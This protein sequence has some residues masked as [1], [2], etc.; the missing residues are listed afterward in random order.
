[1][2]IGGLIGGSQIKETVSM[3]PELNNIIYSAWGLFLIGSLYY[4]VTISKLQNNHPFFFIMFYISIFLVS[5]GFT[6]LGLLPFMNAQIIPT[7]NGM[8]YGMGI[9]IFILICLALYGG[10]EKRVV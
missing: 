4:Y 5:F 8:L 3:N 10:R 7:S 2:I 1:L 9:Q 6:V